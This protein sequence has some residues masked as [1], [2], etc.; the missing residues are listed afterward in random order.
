MT[1][2]FEYYEKLKKLQAVRRTN[3][4][5]VAVASRRRKAEKKVGLTNLK[6]VFLMN[7]AAS[8]EVAHYH[9]PVDDKIRSWARRA[10][11]AWSNLADEMD[12]AA[13]P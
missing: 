10:A 2:A 3:W 1:K 8:V 11:D 12:A 13:N 4:Q 9:G 5:K 6:N 7:C